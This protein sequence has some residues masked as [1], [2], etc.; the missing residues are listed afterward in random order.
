VIH[1]ACDG[2]S[3]TDEQLRAELEESG[4]I[5]DV[6]SGA[7]TSKALRLTAET[8]ALMRYATLPAQAIETDKSRVQHKAA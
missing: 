5:T 6:Q 2:L 4:D 3:I 8:L 1:F 7:L